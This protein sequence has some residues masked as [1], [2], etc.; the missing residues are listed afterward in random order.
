MPSATRPKAKELKV[1]IHPAG[2]PAG[3]QPGEQRSVRLTLGGISLL[4][5]P[6]ES[7]PRSAD[8]K[9]TKPFR[10]HQATPR[11]VGCSTN[12]LRCRLRTV[13]FA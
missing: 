8:L 1:T 6:R 12:R 13:A 7:A 9:D 3:G 11:C 10:V 2:L 5:V 4:A